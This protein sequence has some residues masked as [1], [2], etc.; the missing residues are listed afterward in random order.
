MYLCMCAVHANVYKS[1]HTQNGLRFASNVHPSLGVWLDEV[2][3][4]KTLGA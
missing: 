3:E 4:M 2:C 1:T